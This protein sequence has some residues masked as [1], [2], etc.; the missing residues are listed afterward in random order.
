MRTVRSTPA[1]SPGHDVHQTTVPCWGSRLC[2]GTVR[3][4]GSTLSRSG[5]ENPFLSPV[6]VQAV[7][8][9]AGGRRFGKTAGRAEGEEPRLMITAPRARSLY[10]LEVLCGG[11]CVS[12]TGRSKG[13]A[14]S[15]PDFTVCPLKTV[16]LCVPVACVAHTLVLG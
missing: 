13:C 14:A 2:T 8:A 1:P 4:A 6:C 7:G 3:R 9:S 5:G 10:G 12:F 15:A 11:I 16:S